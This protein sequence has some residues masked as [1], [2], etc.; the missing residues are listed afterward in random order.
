MLRRCGPS[1][2]S[3]SARRHRPTPYIFAADRSRHSR[4]AQPTE[5]LTRIAIWTISTPLGHIYTPR[6][7]FGA[8]WTLWSVE[9]RVISGALET[10]RTAGTS[11]V[12]SP[13]G[14]ELPPVYR[15]F[16]PPLFKVSVKPRSAH[17]VVRFRKGDVDAFLE[18]LS[19]DA[20]RV[21]AESCPRR[22]PV[23][24]GSGCQR[25]RVSGSLSTGGPRVRRARERPPGW[26]GYS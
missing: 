4:F 17:S 15:D 12:L 5:P 16:D 26:L 3:P 23:P 21:R 19:E 11:C 18:S 10:P 2:G 14:R 22:D 6:A 1:A 9:V 8:L 25:A 7:W 13:A 24:Q 20:G